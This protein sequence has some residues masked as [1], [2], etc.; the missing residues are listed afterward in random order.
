MIRDNPPQLKPKDGFIALFLSALFIFAYAYFELKELTTFIFEL[1]C[2]FLPSLIVLSFKGGFKTV[3]NPF[4]VK[5]K[6][7][8]LSF[9]TFLSA[10]LL[11]F[12]S[13]NLINIF[14][15]I[16]E[17]IVELERNILRF[18]FFQQVLIFAIFPAVFEEILFR[19]VILKSFAKIGKNFSFLLTSTLFTLYHGSLELFLPIFILSLFL[20]AIAFLRA[21]LTLSI[22]FHFIFN[23]LNLISLNY[24]KFEIGFFASIFIVIVSFP[25]FIYSILKVLKNA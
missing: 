14:F 2:I 16:S 22:L 25:F 10:S 21:G 11:G 23:F 8:K 15:D 24:L 9:F 5:N 12:S 13:G 20:T 6:E 19:G 3:L 17:T 7:F 18:G 1:F 4:F